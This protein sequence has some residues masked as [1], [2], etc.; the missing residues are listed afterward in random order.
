VTPGAQRTE[1]PDAFQHRQR[2]VHD[3]DPAG[4]Q[5]DHGC[6]LARGVR[7]GH[8][9]AADRGVELQGAEMIER[10]H[11]GAGGRHLARIGLDPGDQV[12]HRGDARVRSGHRHQLDLVEPHEIGH[13][14]DLVGKAAP[15]RGQH[16]EIG[17]RQQQGVPIGR[18]LGDVVRRDRRGGARPV[19]DDDRMVHP[20]LQVLGQEAREHVRDGA[21][22]V[23]HHDLDRLGSGEGLRKGRQGKEQRRE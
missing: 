3:V 11:S 5:V 19:F 4:A 21:R 9:L 22:A 10:P 7:H 15:H 16:D 1:D 12:L 18:G 17:R 13:V 6:A 14:L 23:G 20:G 2:A 8:G